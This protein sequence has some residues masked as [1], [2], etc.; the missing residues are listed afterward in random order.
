MDYIAEIAGHP[1]QVQPS[2]IVITSKYFD[3]REIVSGRRALT[4]KIDRED[5][6]NI[7]LKLRDG[8][9]LYKD[10]AEVVGVS[11]QAVWRMYH[12]YAVA[13]RKEIIR[14]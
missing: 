9:A 5:R 14:R 13:D 8:G 4:R 10:I 7:V 2:H 1:N 6:I 12:H 11:E 3:T